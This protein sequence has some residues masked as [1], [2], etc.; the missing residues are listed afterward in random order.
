MLEKLIHE[1]IA[2]N[3]KVNDAETI[4][5]IAMQFANHAMKRCTRPL[6]CSIPSALDAHSIAPCASKLF[7]FTHHVLPDSI[8]DHT[9]D[10]KG[11]HNPTH[12][13]ETARQPVNSDL[14][15]PLPERPPPI[16]IIQIQS[17]Q[18][19]WCRQKLDASRRKKLRD[20]NS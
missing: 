11:R 10:S 2:C 17:Q 15:Q 13:R 19:Q 6:V 5:P 8:V 20:R 14:P 1:F 3:R 16:S 4:Q 18:M 9:A 7:Q 12:P